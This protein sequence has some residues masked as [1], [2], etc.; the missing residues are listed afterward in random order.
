MTRRDHDSRSRAWQAADAGT[1]YAD[2]R[3]RGPRAAGRD[4]RAFRR[5]LQPLTAS[6]AGHRALDVP[7]GTGRLRSVLQDTGV[8]WI[9]ADISSSMLKE[10][11]PAQAGS[12][13]RADA[14]RLPLADRSVELVLCC[15]LLHHVQEEAELVALLTEFMRVTR[16]WLVA[17]FWDSSS[18]PAWRAG[19]RRGHDGE[20]RVARTRANLDECVRAAGGEIRS[21]GGGIRYLAR[22]CNFLAEKNVISAKAA[23]WRA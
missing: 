22:Q 19:W 7:C 6:L 21:Y 16:R 18:I 3:F 5:L 9:G 12:T 20:R 17:S 2:T 11:H 14:W 13:L 1:H 8:T 4:P 15:R 23:P 10:V